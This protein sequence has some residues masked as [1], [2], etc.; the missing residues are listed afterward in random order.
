MLEKGIRGKTSHEILLCVKT[1][2]KYIKNC[3]K[4]LYLK[5]WDGNNLYGSMLQKLKRLKV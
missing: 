4:S 2:D 5:Y 1:E 3:K